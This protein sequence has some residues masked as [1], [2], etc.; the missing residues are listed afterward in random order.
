MDPIASVLH[1]SFCFSELKEA[2]QD[3]WMSVVLGCSR[4]PTLCAAYMP[5]ERLAALKLRPG[6]WM[7]GVAAAVEV[8][9]AF[10]WTMTR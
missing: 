10:Y 1:L 5:Q 7:E 8:A 3:G 9:T 2:E 6:C 4:E